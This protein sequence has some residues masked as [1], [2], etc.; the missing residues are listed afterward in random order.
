M[1][2]IPSAT[3]EFPGCLSAAACPCAGWDQ[4]KMFQE[5]NIFIPQEI[6]LGAGFS[7]LTTSW[8]ICDLVIG[9]HPENVMPNLK[10]DL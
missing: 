9:L 4:L 2:A 10:Q 6:C 7:F 8:A 1:S 3:W 5:K